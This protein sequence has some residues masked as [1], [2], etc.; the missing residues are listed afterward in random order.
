MLHKTEQLYFRLANTAHRAEIVVEMLV[1]MKE[2]QP[3]YSEFP[4]RRC[5]QFE[6]NPNPLLE[7]LVL[8]S[9]TV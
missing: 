2:F 1:G 5:L 3:Y 8:M 7:E 9:T 6:K 4:Q